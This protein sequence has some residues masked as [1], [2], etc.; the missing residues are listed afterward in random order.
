MAT[1]SENR[2]VV[3]IKRHGNT[4]PTRAP[5]RLFP[6]QAAL[7]VE[8]AEFRMILAST[9]PPKNKPSARNHMPQHCAPRVPRRHCS[10]FSSDDKWST[11]EKAGSARSASRQPPVASSVHQYPKCGPEI[12]TYARMSQSG[13]TRAYL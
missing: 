8:G 5:C 13:W 4:L 12:V 9:L 7:V 10:K 1:K 2:L 3:V 11:D 6:R